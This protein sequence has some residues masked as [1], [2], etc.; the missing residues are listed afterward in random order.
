MPRCDGPT[1]RRIGR[2]NPLYRS[3]AGGGR[4][5]EESLGAGA[6]RSSDGSRIWSAPAVVAG[7]SAD[8]ETRAY[9]VTCPVVAVDAARWP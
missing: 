5:I 4:P 2:V 3:P 7:A 6:G 8:S 9:E 1:G